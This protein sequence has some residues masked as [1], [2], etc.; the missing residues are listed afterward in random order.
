MCEARKFRTAFYPAILFSVC[1]MDS[2]LLF[3]QDQG[4][5][6]LLAR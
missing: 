3:P 5:T 1:Y 6:I 2:R 4:L